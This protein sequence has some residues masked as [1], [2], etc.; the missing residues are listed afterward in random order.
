MLALLF[1]SSMPIPRNLISEDWFKTI[2]TYNPMSYLIEATAASS[3]P[4]G[5]QRRWRSACGIAAVG[6]I[7]APPRFAGSGQELADDRPLPVHCAG[8]GPAN[9]PG[10]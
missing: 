3:S 9:L 2:A 4:G 7:A 1:L 8:A 6:L 10:S 5:T